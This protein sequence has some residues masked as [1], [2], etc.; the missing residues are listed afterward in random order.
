MF[1]VYWVINVKPIRRMIH[2]V[3]KWHNA[4][5]GVRIEFHMISR[6]NN[7]IG[8]ACLGCVS[9]SNVTHEAFVKRCANMLAWLCRVLENPSKTYY[10]IQC[11]HARISRPFAIFGTFLD[12]FLG[13]WSIYITENISEYGLPKPCWHCL[14]PGQAPL[15]W[16]ERIQL[17]IPSSLQKIQKKLR[18]PVFSRAIT[19]H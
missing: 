17:M 1:C 7:Y 8:S 9:I 18:L 11:R 2:F 15:H 13:R 16:D 10:I 19:N 6:K 14:N 4:A 5:I 12:Q 3:K